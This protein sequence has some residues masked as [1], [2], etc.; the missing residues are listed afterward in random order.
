MWIARAKRADAVHGRQPAFSRWALKAGAETPLHRH[1]DEQIGWI[2]SG[3]S[4]MGS[5]GRQCVLQAG[6][7]M[8]FPPNVEH[9]IDVFA[10]L[11]QDRIDRAAAGKRQ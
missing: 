10:P 6:D 9:A 8:L 4:R 1:A 5:A 7:I 2:V 3:R 11:R